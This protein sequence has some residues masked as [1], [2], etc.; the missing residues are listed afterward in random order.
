MKSTLILFT[1]I[2][3]AL[4]RES[5]ERRMGIRKSQ[6]SNKEYQS[7]SIN[8]C[9]VPNYMYDNIYIPYVPEG[10]SMFETKGMDVCS[11]DSTQCILADTGK[12]GGQIL[13][14]CHKC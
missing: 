6:N 7:V 5:R 9:V 12:P 3:S 10:E 1:L 2:S 13:G 8:T 11:D 4:N 14:E